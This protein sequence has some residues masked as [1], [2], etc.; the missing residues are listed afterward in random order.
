MEK[1]EEIETLL[2]HLSRMVEELSDVVARQDKELRQ[3]TAQ[4]TLLLERE[5]LREADEGSALF[6]D[7]KPPPHY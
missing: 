7:Q 4:V 5:A 2:M 3:I 1:L 6:G